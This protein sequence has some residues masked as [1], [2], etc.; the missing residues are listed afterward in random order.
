MSDQIRSNIAGGIEV[1]ALVAI[2]P[3]MLVGFAVAFPL[4]LLADKIH[5]HTYSY[6]G[7]KWD[8][9][10]MEYYVKCETCGRR[11]KSDGN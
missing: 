3:L 10:E 7:S 1:V 8:E 5:S 6:G 4:Q 11:S 9:E 2:L